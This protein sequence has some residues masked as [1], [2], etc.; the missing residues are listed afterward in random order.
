MK[1]TI[2]ENL[3]IFIFAKDKNLKF[4][5]C[6]ENFAAAAGL[7]SPNQV[8]GKTDYEMYWKKH[9]DFYRNGDALVL[10]GHAKINQLEIQTQP[11]KIANVLLTK[12]ILQDKNKNILGIVGSYIDIS[13][14]SLKKNAGRFDE[15]EHRFYLGDY[16]N[17]EYFT[18]NELEIFKRLLLGWSVEKISN[19]LCRSKKTTETHIGNIKL[20]LQ[21]SSKNEIIPRA[22]EFGLTYILEHQV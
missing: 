2:L 9:A 20:K 19:F 16:F 6:N 4:L 18:K 3:N 8:I 17:N 10:N 1:E 21:C 15:K 13:G 12:N 22:I 5:Y 7:D 11:T 14:Y